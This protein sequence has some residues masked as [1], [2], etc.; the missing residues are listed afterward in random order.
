MPFPPV[1][2]P[3]AL[4]PLAPAPRTASDLAAALILARGR[5]KAND[6][7]GA[8][9]ALE[10]LAGLVPAHPE[11]ADALAGAYRRDARYG[12]TLA[13]A[14]AVAAAGAAPGPQLLYEQAM[15]LLLLGQAPEALAAF[16]HLLVRAP[17][18]AAGW[19]WSHAPALDLLGWAEGE[20][21][22]RAAAAIPGGNR[23]YQ[24]F[25]AAYDILRGVDD[26]RPCPV[27][28][29]YLADA[30]AALRPLIGGALAAGPTDAP[31][32]RLFGVAAHLL[33]YA[34]TQAATAGL[35]LEFG[36]RRGNSIAV[37]ARGAGQVVH[38]FDSFEGL[39]EAWVN[40]PAGV[41]TTGGA[42]PVVPDNVRLHAGW[43]EQS[44]PPFLAA[45]PGPV[46][47]V[48]I[49]S[50]IY[51]SA[52]TVLWALA[53]RIVSGTVLVFDEMIGNRSWADD[54]YKAFREY[55]ATFG[56]DWQVIAV[57]LAGK[58]VALRRR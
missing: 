42:L 3:S 6:P 29:R 31:P 51:S 46:R 34:L 14:R 15:A 19:F 58:Q 30:A 40:A 57:N 23:K 21:R 56:G 9:A 53:D 1:P 43:F 47:F 45:H 8:V 37:L 28:H 26:P 35:V 22:L 20:R 7:G 27:A 12:D 32:P 50:D 44:L 36:V 39:P 17:D 25:L 18:R 5:V 49:D 13:V 10:P 24:A 2:P 52:R 33:T 48:N 41:L 55:T 16:D 4:P 54:E 38:G 11:L